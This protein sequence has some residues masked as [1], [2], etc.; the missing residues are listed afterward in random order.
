MHGN[1]IKKM[2]IKLSKNQGHVKE[3]ERV[4]RKERFDKN[5]I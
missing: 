5:S 2:K 1:L 3:R 4:R